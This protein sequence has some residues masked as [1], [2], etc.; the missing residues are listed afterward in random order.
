MFKCHEKVY[1]ARGR[2][3]D[4]RNC[5]AGRIR[6]RADK[7]AIVM[8]RLRRKVRL[9]NSSRPEIWSSTIAATYLVSVIHCFSPPH[10][11]SMSDQ[12]QT[13]N[14]GDFLSLEARTRA[15]SAIKQL[16]PYFEIPG[17]ISVS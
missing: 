5:A 14:Y 7:W 2:L 6:T 1:M 13:P 12:A 16:R 3:A 11:R 15:R 4:W 9:R 10:S 17:M 8:T